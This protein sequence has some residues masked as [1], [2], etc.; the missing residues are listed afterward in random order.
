MSVSENQA[1]D[2]VEESLK[3]QAEGYVNLLHITLRPPEQAQVSLYMTPQKSVEWQGRTWETFQYA[4]V[5]YKVS[6]DEESAR[7][8]LT[9]INPEGVFTR[10]A[11]QGWLDNALIVRYGVLKRHLDANINSFTKNTWRVAKI[12]QASKQIVSMELRAATDGQLYYLPAR[13]YLPPVFPQVS[14]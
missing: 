3:L 5:G 4:L 11:T 13:Q 12:V 2:H 1:Q 8:K 7:P 6:A 9:V 10:Y 14:M